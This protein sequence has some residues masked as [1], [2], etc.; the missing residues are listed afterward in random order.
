MPPKK[1][2]NEKGAQKKTFLAQASSKESLKQ[3][4][5]RD[6]EPKSGDSELNGNTTAASAKVAD[7]AEIVGED[8]AF[9]ELLKP[10]YHGKAL[11]D[12]IGT[13]EDKWRLLPAFL[14]VKGLVKQH[15]DSYNYFIDVGMKQI[16]AAN[17]WV[18]SSVHDR[19][20]LQYLDIRVEHPNRYYEDSLRTHEVSTVTPNECRLVDST[21]AAPIVVDYRYWRNN[22]IVY[23]RNVRIGRLPIMLRSN[24]CI[25]TGKSEK[26]MAQLHECPIDP[27]GYFIVKGQEK[28]V[29]VQEQLS[30]NR[31]IV[32][33]DADIYQASVTR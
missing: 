26:D 4:H 16:V 5:A 17:A 22:T 12:S 31:I 24:R 10:Q 19:F 2:Q 8:E 3:N 6:R 25:L 28:V 20:W 29:L 18:T 32:E 21:Y 33:S 15:I 11:T 9:K 13:P 1:K 7:V 14:K 23:R 30:K 27:G